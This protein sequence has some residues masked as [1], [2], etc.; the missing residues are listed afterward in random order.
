MGH[1]LFSLIQKVNQQIYP[2]EEN[3]SNKTSFSVS[4]KFRSTGLIT[5]TLILVLGTIPF[6][7]IFIGSKT[8]EPFEIVLCSLLL[9]ITFLIF[10]L[11]IPSVLSAKGNVGL[12]E[13]GILVNS[14]SIP[15]KDITQIKHNYLRYSIT[16]CTEH[17]SV[18][19]T[20]FIKGFEKLFNVI[21]SNTNLATIK[22]GV[23]TKPTMNYYVV[24]VVMGTSLS[25]FS[26]LLIPFI[27]E[28]NSSFQ[29]LLIIS[30][31]FMGIWLVSFLCA[32]EMFRRYTFF[33]D[34][35]IEHT[36]IGKRK[37]TYESMTSLALNK[38]QSTII[39][40][41]NKS[42]KRI[43]PPVGISLAELYGFLKSKVNAYSHPN[44]NQSEV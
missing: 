3:E 35:F 40:M 9:I 2:S 34:F 32:L 36:A 11:S 31:V 17:E 6:I 7:T 33:K 22:M 13:G 39:C 4:K 19:V 18:V 27:V 21:L 25:L 20:K 26:T 24:S 16:V 23:R 30:S 15:F 38:G 10:S 8:L 43:F 37:I 29:A 12:S 14:I 44:N 42:H 1:F 28:E 41:I 5:L